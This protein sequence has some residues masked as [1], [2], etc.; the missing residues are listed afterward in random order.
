MDNNTVRRAEQILGYGIT[1]TAG[2]R[3]YTVVDGIVYADLFTG[4]PTVDF[5]GDIVKS[6]NGVRNGVTYFNQIELK[7]KCLPK[8]VTIDA[9]WGSTEFDTDIDPLTDWIAQDDVTDTLDESGVSSKKIEDF[10][11]TYRNSEEAGQAKG[12]ALADGWSWYIR[13]PLI[14]GVSREQKDG[15]RYF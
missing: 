6:F 12:N 14:V 11:V 13:T 1:K 5:S 4:D 7:G 10:S 3:T 15:G 9:L 8:E 2:D